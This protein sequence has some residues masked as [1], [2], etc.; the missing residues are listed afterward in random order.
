MENSRAKKRPLKRSSPST[1][2]PLYIFRAE[3]DA[4]TLEGIRRVSTLL[5]AIVS[6]APGMTAACNSPESSQITVRV[7]DLVQIQSETLDR[8]KQVTEE[9]FGPLGVKITWRHCSA[10]QSREDQACSAPTGLN[11]ISLR[12]FQRGKARLN[13]MRHWTAGMAVPL[14]P[15]GGRG[16]IY[17]FL[18]RVVAVAESYRVPLELALGI[19]VAH[20][21]GRLLLLGEPHALAGIMRA[22]LSRDDWRLAG[23]GHLGFTTARG[24]SSGLAS[25]REVRGR[26]KVQTNAFASFPFPTTNYSIQ[27]GLR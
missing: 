9:V 27:I 5:M 26:L 17:V 18:D 10:G 1:P 2:F 4:M 3:V 19:T 11:D 7:L 14:T 21:I 25:R 12:I 24:R 20:E 22:K 23:Q 16:I 6:H 15:E 13:G 8:T